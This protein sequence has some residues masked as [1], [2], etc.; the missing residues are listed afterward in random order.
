MSHTTCFVKP[1]SDLP[2]LTKND[3]EVLKSIIQQAKIP[4]TD[5]AKKMG[6]SPQAVFK[7]R[8]K[9][10]EL[11]IIK[12]Y[13]PILDLKKLGI[14][15]MALLVIKLLPEVW[16]NYSDAEI[17]ERIK[18]IPYIVDAYRVPESNVTHILLM[19]FRDLE[20]MDRHLAKM[21]TRFA[22]EVDIQHVYPF[23]TDKIITQSPIGLLYEVLDK[24]EFP[25]DEFFLKRKK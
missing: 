20:Q 8:H 24:R 22:R 16:D 4:D 3:Q 21:Q 14:N 2:R 15:V 23:S 5:I 25:M 9:L 6:I 10:E 13:T 19:G 11:G 17:A 18:Q 7:I 1:R 12:G